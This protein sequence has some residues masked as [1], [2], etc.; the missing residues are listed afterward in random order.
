RNPAL[1]DLLL[2]WVDGDQSPSPVDDG[3]HQKLRAERLAAVG[4]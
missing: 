1:A 3:W 4:A 2:G